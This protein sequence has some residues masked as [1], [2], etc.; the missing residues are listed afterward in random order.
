MKRKIKKLLREGINKSKIINDINNF[1]DLEFYSGTNYRDL[2]QSCELAKGNC[3]DVSEN[4]YSYLV[5]MGYPDNDLTIVDLHV[6][7]FDTSNSHHEW[8]DYDKEFL[9]HVVLKYK[10][11]FIDL[12]GAQ[13]SKE[14]GGIKLYTKK[15][16]LN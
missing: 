12:T 5:K 8:Q 10:N 16:L 14:Q 4:L 9:F 13:F 3:M 6:P 7:K 15:E 2:L 11:L 1:L